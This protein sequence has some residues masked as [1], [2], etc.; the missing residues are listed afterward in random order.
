MN[1]ILKMAVVFLCTTSLLHSQVGTT[2]S[3][4]DLSFRG[5]QLG[6]TLAQWKANP[7]N[8]S[9]VW[10][11]TGNPNAWRVDK[12]KTIHMTGGWCDDSGILLP[13]IDDANPGD[14]TCSVGYEGDPVG[15]TDVSNQTITHLRYSFRDGSLYNISFR[16]GS[17]SYSTFKAAFAAKYGPAAMTDS[18]PYENGFGANWKG[19]AEMRTYGSTIIYLVEGPGDG[20]GQNG[21]DASKGGGAYISNSTVD[22]QLRGGQ[23]AKAVVDF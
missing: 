17:S 20:P 23:A 16:F 1:L 21:N 10:V 18:I 6:M 13:G 14:V 12:K 22:K 8:A 4:P 15:T 2:T 7:Q 9:S 3:V 11:N 19:E 5:N